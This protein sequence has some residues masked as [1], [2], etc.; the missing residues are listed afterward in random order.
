MT[1]KRVTTRSTITGEK[2]TTAPKRVR[3]TKKI[4]EPTTDVVAVDHAAIAVRAYERFLARGAVHGFDVED[5]LAAER[6]L[7]T[8]R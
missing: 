3:A 2:K 6:E 8:A 7:Q 1:T 4:D 5:W